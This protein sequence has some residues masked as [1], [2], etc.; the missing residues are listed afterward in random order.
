MGATRNWH[1]R[2]PGGKTPTR[3]T[4]VLLFDSAERM[5]EVGFYDEAGAPF[6]QDNTA[7]DPETTWWRPLP[8]APDGEAL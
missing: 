2:M 5:V 3:Y 7:A 8:T 6:Y 4:R 1:W